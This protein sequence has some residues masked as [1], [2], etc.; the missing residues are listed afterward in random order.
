MSIRIH[1]GLTVDLDDD[2]LAEW[3]AVTGVPAQPGGTVRAKDSV[4]AMRDQAPEALRAYFTG[5]GVRADISI[6]Q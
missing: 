5:L 6:K 1:I 3:A 4:A 2:Q